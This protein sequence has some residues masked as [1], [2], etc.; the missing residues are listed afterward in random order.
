MRGSEVRVA[1]DSKAAQGGG[2]FVC[3][4]FPSRPGKQTREG[5]NKQ[6]LKDQG[7][8]SMQQRCTF[9]DAPFPMHLFFLPGSERGTDG[10]DNAD[11]TK[12]EKSG[13][14]RG[15]NVFEGGQEQR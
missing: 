8:L 14:T 6:K 2:R 4:S 11:T 1:A 10:R 13:E 5:G 3:G 15:H 7:Q 9:F 12:K